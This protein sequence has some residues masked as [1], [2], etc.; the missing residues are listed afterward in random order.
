MQTRLGRAQLDYWPEA[1]TIAD[2][3]IVVSGISLLRLVDVCGTPGVH[4][5]AAVVPAS[6]RRD[7]L[8]AHH[9]ADPE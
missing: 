7:C 5:G 3:D 8:A 1:T 4:S 2:T 9:P 6:R